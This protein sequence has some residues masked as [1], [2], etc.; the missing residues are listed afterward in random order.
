LGENFE[1]DREK[2][3]H[4]HGGLAVVVG[5]TGKG[6]RFPLDRLRGRVNGHGGR[7]NE[8][9]RREQ[10]GRKPEEKSVHGERWE[11]WKNLR[12]FGIGISARILG[13]RLVVGG[14]EGSSPFALA[15]VFEGSKRIGHSKEDHS[16]SDE[17]Y[18]EDG[19]APSD[20]F[21]GPIPLAGPFEDDLPIPEN[22]DP[23][24]DED[25]EIEEFDEHAKGLPRQ[26]MGCSNRGNRKNPQYL[27]IFNRMW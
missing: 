8:N 14:L 25:C 1:Q 15:E 20:V 26:Y 27:I 12:N 2:F 4:R 7:R 18:D 23:E 24:S 13:F 22:G 5:I 6:G 10:S 9:E 19:S 11:K 16:H 3:L 17:R 21:F